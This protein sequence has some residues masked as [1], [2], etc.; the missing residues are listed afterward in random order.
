MWIGLS[1]AKTF[2]VY[3]AME[4]FNVL[5]FIPEAAFYRY[6]CPSWEMAAI[7]LAALA[8]D[9]L[10]QF[11]SPR[12]L[13][14]LV[15][16]GVIL[17]VIGCV[18]FPARELLLTLSSKPRFWVFFLS[19]VGWAIASILLLMVAATRAPLF[20]RSAMLVAVAVID[21]LLLFVF[22]RFS[23][24]RDYRLNLGGVEFLQKNLG[25]SRFYSLGPIAPNY[26]PY[27]G[28]ASINHIDA[29]IPARWVE[30]I[31]ERLDSNNDNGSNFLGTARR[32]SR[33]PSAAEELVRNL[34]NYEGLGV[35]YIVAPTAENPFLKKVTFGDHGTGNVPLPLNNGDGVEGYLSGAIPPGWLMGLEVLV[36]TYHG[37]AN[38]VL[39]ATLQTPDGVRFTAVADVARAADNQF[40]RLEFPEPIE[41][42]S[43][44]F[45]QFQFTLTES[46]FPVALW[47]YPVP[48]ESAQ[49]LQQGN[50][51]L[52]GH[53]AIKLVYQYPGETPLA[54][55][56]YHDA[57]MSIYEL[58]APKSYFTVPE[59]KCTLQPLSREALIL[60]CTDSTQLVRRE[61][62]FPGWSATVNDEE[63]TI[64]VHD[65]LFQQISIPAGRSTVQF[66][67]YPLFLKWA[68]LAAAIAFGVLLWHS[69]SCYML[70]RFHVVESDE[71]RFV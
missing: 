38:G 37:H 10:V 13:W 18:L 34:A 28:I 31:A 52:D 20:L 70:Q 25:L 63:V 22:P 56:V 44:T 59:D 16:L 2:G 53:L 57:V 43:T 5:P 26:G 64:S 36:G 17:L 29:P 46:T 7:V 71:R 6:A 58:S 19:S 24:P 67:F 48:A 65:N 66:V 4:L 8:F 23:S 60:D 51:M 40:L 68:V 50:R 42:M 3:W 49:R 11:R 35:K 69:I 21:A 62:Y 12:W 41:V 47:R 9:D 45:L 14:Y 55:L 32:D 54:K 39:R 61:L 15:P 30:Y 33:G 1:L 27:F